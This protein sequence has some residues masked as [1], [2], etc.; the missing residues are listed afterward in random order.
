MGPVT[1][2]GLW[3]GKWP[4]HTSNAFLRLLNMYF[5]L[6]REALHPIQDVSD[7]IILGQDKFFQ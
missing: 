4:G 2:D 6:W 5:R 7:P 1:V 3:N